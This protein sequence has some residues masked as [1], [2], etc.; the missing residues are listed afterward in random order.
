MAMSRSRRAVT[1]GVDGH[2]EG[3]TAGVD[4]ATDVVVNPVGV[5]EHIELK[6]LEA[7][8]RGLGRRSETGSG[9]VLAGKPSRGT[10]PNVT[11]TTGA[12]D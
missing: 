10:A 7:I 6:D 11:S 4:R 12:T 2:A 8:A 1:V 3:V 9:A 5:A